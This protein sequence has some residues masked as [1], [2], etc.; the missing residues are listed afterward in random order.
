MNSDIAQLKDIAQE[1]SVLY[2]E[3]EE[4]LREGVSSYL[5]K[6]F[7][8]VDVASN[9]KEGLECFRKFQ[10]DL[11]I[12]DINMPVLS[13]LDMAK[14]IKKINE[15][16]NILIVSAYSDTQN[17]IESIK[18]GID[19]YILKPIEYN[20]L[21]TEL[22]K[23]TFKIK[24]FK[25]SIE[26]KSLLEQLVETKTE[27]VKELQKQKMYNY[28][29]TLYAL[30]KMVEDRDTYT[31]GHSLRVAKYSKMIAQNL[32]LDEKTCKNIYEAGIL[33]DIGKIAIPDN[34]LLKP[35]TLDKLEYTLIQ[36]H[37]NLGV[38][39]LSKVPMFRE[40][41]KF[42]DG[43]HEKLDGSGYPKGLKGDQI[44]L[45][46][47]IMAISDAFDAMTTSRIYKARKS[48]PEALN[49]L[50]NLSG[51]HYRADVVQSAITV[52]KDITIDINISQLPTTQ[53]EKERFSY[54]YKDQT[55]QSYNSNYL[56]LILRQ[57]VYDKKYK[58]LYII[59]IHNL[60]QINIVYGWEQG[61]EF[62][63]DFYKKLESIFSEYNIFRIFS[64]DFVLLSDIELDIDRKM[65]QNIISKEEISFDIKTYDIEEEK[66]NS[67]HSL[68]TLH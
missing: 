15:N 28:K 29:N 40:L 8:I 43:H 26:Y 2:V 65:I 55:T 49:E 9:G 24:Q 63:K 52:L 61:N 35:G 30:V 14:E 13:G 54:F 7:K 45:E 51:K 19:G 57:N 62:L 4:K 5:S 38:K 3:D 27:D 66:M 36:E 50:K 25:E 58:Y 31:G 23:T 22:Y 17:F 32:N 11:I 47:Q 12:T 6:F 60:N 68:E 53:I 33:H 39:M 34:V 56:D 44:A 16:Q 18:I 1:L 41:A 37:V 42:I 48:I 46:S 64:D 67:M 21:N 20:Q 59:S 10:Y